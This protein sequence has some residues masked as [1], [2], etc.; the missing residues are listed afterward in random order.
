MRATLGPR[1]PSRF[2]CAHSTSNISVVL[3]RSAFFL[4][5][6]DGERRAVANAAEG[7]PGGA[8]ALPGGDGG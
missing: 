7:V 4:G 8:K 2:R 3:R 1:T 6:G 5:G